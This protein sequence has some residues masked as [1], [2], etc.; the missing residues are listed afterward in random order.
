M[1][2]HHTKINLIKI[3]NSTFKRYTNDHGLRLF[4]LNKYQIYM[5]LEKLKRITKKQQQ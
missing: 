3:Y 4:R 5:F 1:N 2:F